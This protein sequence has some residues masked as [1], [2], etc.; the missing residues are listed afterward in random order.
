MNEIKYYAGLIDAD[1]SFILK[2]YKTDKGYV[3]RSQF[4]LELKCSSEWVMLPL[5]DEFSAPICKC[6]RTDIRTGETY[7]SVYLYITSDRCV[8]LMEQLRQHLVVKQPLVDALLKF[9]K[10][11]VSKEE[12]K[13]IR[14]YCKAARDCLSPTHKTKV[15]RQ[16]MAGYID[17]DGSISSSYRKRGGCLSFKLTVASNVNDPQGL[18]L[19]HKAFGGFIVYGKN[20]E[21]WWGLHIGRNNIEK[22]F[23]HFIQHLKLR[24]KQANLV[25]SEVRN[26]PTYKRNSP[27]KAAHN[28]D[29][30]NTLKR[31]KT[32]ND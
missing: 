31:L 26:R 18:V 19:L 9:D 4:K 11:V 7:E 8:R 29:V 13:Q 23:G 30:H 5:A 17:G 32:S 27:E 15:S 2:P 20:N 14:T 28:L 25:I 21:M 10:H 6:S 22:V 24:R 16:W 12:L 3:I 1:G